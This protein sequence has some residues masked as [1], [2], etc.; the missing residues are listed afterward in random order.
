MLI[1]VMLNA[2]MLSVVMLNA[3]MLIVVMLNTIILSVVAPLTVHHFTRRLLALLAKRRLL[4]TNTLA[5][6]V[7]TS[8]I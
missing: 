2:I 6:F 4:H 8:V 1:V 7:Q 3:I 5:Y